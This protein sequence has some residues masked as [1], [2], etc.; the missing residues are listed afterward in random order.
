MLDA[1]ATLKKIQQMSFPARHKIKYLYVHKHT[2]KSKTIDLALLTMSGDYVEY[3]L[4]FRKD[5]LT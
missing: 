2:A 1:L 5:C 3:T 4:D